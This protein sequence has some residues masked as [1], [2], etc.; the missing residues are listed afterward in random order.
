MFGFGGNRARKGSVERKSAPAPVVS[1]LSNP[2]SWLL[3]LFG[4]SPVSSGVS[5]TPANATSCPAVRCAVAAISEAIGQLPIHVYQ[6][7]QDGTRERASDHP[8]QGL[9][10]DEANDFTPA[11]SFREELTRDALLHENG[12]FAFIN[13]V[14]DRPVELLRLDPQSVSVETDTTGAPVYRISAGNVQRLYARQ[15]I[16]HLRAPGGSPVKHCREAIGLAIALEQ[17]AARLFA[18]G[19]RPSGVLQ[20]NSQPLLSPE[21]LKAAAKAFQDAHSR[22]RS[23]GVA[24]LLGGEFKPLT[25]TS[26][27]AQFLE[28]R[29]FAIAEIARAFRVPP[30]LLMDYGRQTWANA[31]EGGR[32]FLQY[33]LL[34]WMDRWQGE[35]RLKLFAPDERS[36]FFAEFLTDDLL[37]ADLDKRADAYGKL[38]A[39]RILNPNEVRALENRAPYKGGDEFLNPNTTS[40]AN[41]N[42]G[43]PASE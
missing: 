9:V 36:T 43:A 22:D 32:Q 2:E 16:F 4:A 10:H 39:A 40:G 35:I 12:A 15:D 18:N 14:D 13:R 37:R 30:V 20:F 6:R 27:D 29:Q 38:I 42:S 34:P 7:G 3:D 41:A 21:A 33:T 28:L 8:V 31:E 26:V 24:P 19:A 23:G 5:V 1:T 17:H 25:F 11:S